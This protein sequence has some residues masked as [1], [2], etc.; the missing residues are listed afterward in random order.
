M[1][2]RSPLT[3]PMRVPFVEALGVELHRFGDGASELRLDL[4][5][6]HLNTWQVAHGGVSM[7]MLDVAMA[8]AARS[9]HGQGSG[10]AT[11]EMKT[12]FLRPAQGQLRAV[13][14]LLH[15]TATLAFCE[16]T[17]HDGSGALCAS[18]SGTF[19]YL[20]GLSARGRSGAPA[21]HP[22]DPPKEA[23]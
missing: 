19:K 20:R 16:G 3:F 12:S 23:P 7:T 18:A 10:V 5:P 17:L 15:S 4:A 22:P 11:I 8:L 1:K 21:P 9:G 2:A 6:T 14:R 13:G